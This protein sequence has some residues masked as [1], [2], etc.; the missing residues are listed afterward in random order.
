MPGVPDPASVA[1][2]AARA[3]L[4]NPSIPSTGGLPGATIASELPNAGGLAAA[5]AVGA[6]GGYALSNRG[7]EPPQT[8]GTTAGTSTGASEPARPT[9]PSLSGSAGAGLEGFDADKLSDMSDQSPKYQFGRIAQ[10]MDLSSVKDRTSAEAMLYYMRPRLEASGI[11][12][13]AVSGGRIQTLDDSGAPIWVDVLRGVSSG[14]PV[15]TWLPGK[16]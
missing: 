2:D 5:G 3:A 1:S 11:P 10:G 4:G 9:P 6:V 12:V 7:T 8:G 13:L 15:F 16:A 14:K